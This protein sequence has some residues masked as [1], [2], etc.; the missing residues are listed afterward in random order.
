MLSRLA[1]SRPAIFQ[2]GENYW[3]RRYHLAMDAIYSRYRRN[4]YKQ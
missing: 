1:L 4:C 3:T 2:I